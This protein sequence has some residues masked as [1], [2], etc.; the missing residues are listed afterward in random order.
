MEMTGNS[1]KPL[2]GPSEL[3]IGAGEKLIRLEVASV[4]FGG[5]TIGEGADD[6]TAKPE[7]VNTGADA[8]EGKLYAGGASD[9]E[10]AIGV[11]PNFSADFAGVW[12]EK[13]ALLSDLVGVPKLKPAVVFGGSRF[14]VD[15]TVSTGVGSS[16]FSKPESLMGL[17]IKAE[18][19]LG[20]GAA[21]ST[22]FSSIFGCVASTI[23]LAIIGLS[24]GASSSSS[25]SKPSLR[26]LRI[27][28]SLDFSTCFKLTVLQFNIGDLSLGLIK[29]IRPPS[30]SSSSCSSLSLTT[31][32][33][34]VSSYFLLNNVIFGCVGV[35]FIGGIISE[36]L[37][38]ICGNGADSNLLT[39]IGSRC[40][41]LPSVATVAF[42]PIIFS[43][44]VGQV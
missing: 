29:L 30:S 8:V 27:I 7:V 41:T 6:V 20:W 38:T 25:S 10:T 14:T 13:V 26:Q 12:K 24:F 32:L 37:L 23:S 16:F 5:A 39:L 2:F 1:E 18:I 33:T 31:G 17:L 28:D 9:F 44:G 11:L 15:L 4:V 34:T 22:F 36:T 35:G 21:T 3:D 42:N 19:P 43:S 40:S